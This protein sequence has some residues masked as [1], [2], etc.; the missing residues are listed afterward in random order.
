MALGEENTTED[1]MTQLD[2]L[3]AS[4]KKENDAL[5]VMAEVIGKKNDGT[6]TKRKRSTKKN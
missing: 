5:R 4:K 2:D 6:T 3:I 1:I